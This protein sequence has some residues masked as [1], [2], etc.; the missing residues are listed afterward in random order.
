LHAA[1]LAEVQA[2]RNAIRRIAT[3][4]SGGLFYSQ[5]RAAIR[6]IATEQSGGLFYSQARAAIRR[7]AT[8]QSGGLFYSPVRLRAMTMRWIS[9]VPS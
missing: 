8:E 5:A 6:W 4:Q 3:E 2:G 9:L 7:I 1:P